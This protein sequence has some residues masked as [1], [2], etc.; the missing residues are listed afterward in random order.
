MGRS[1][2][3]KLPHPRQT[4]APQ[5]TSQ[6]F[7]QVPKGTNDIQIYPVAPLRTSSLRYDTRDLTDRIQTKIAPVPITSPQY[8]KGTRRSAATLGRMATVNNLNLLP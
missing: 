5:S 3:P 6:Y 4:T 2:C 8:S 1:L 7:T